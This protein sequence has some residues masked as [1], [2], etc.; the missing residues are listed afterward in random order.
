LATSSLWFIGTAALFAATPCGAQ[1]LT[2]LA[3]FDGNNGAYVPAGLVQAT[4]GNLYGTTE[5]GGGCCGAEGDGTVFK[6]SPGGTLTALHNFVGTDGANPQA[7]L[8]Q[9]TDGNLYGTTSGGGGAGLGTVFKITPEGTLTTLHTFLGTDGG[10]PQAGLIQAADGNLYGTT[11]AGGAENDGTVFKITL[12]GTLTTLYS[13]NLSGYA[14]AGLIQAT[15]GNFYGT[16]SGEGPGTGTVFRMTPAG[17]LT[18]LHSFDGPDG[19]NP[20]A[21][22]IQATDGNFYG[23]TAGGGDCCGAEGDG[24][25]FKITTGGTLT[26][27]HSFDEADGENPYAPLIQASDGNFYGTTCLGGAGS[28][29]TVFKITAEGTLTT[30]HGF[31]GTDGS[32]PTNAGLIQATDG[33]LYGTTRLGGAGYLAGGPPYGTVFR[34]QLTGT[35]PY[36]CSNTTPPVITSVESASDY[37]GYSY[38]ASGSWLEIKGSNMADPADPRLSAAVNP[39]QWTAADFSGLNAPTSLDGISASISG[40]PAYVWYLSPGQINVQAPEDSALGNVPITVTNCKATSSPIMFDRRTYAPG[41]LAPANYTANGTQYMVATFASD[42]SYVLNTSTG[43]ALGL[44]SRPAKPGDLIIAYGIGFGDVTPTIPPGVIVTQSNTVVNPI[45]LSFG[46][47]PAILSYS[48]LAGG[49]VGLYEFYIT[50]PPRLT[51]GD[52]EINVTYNGTT[53]PQTMYLTVHN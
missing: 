19:A 36:T 8:I 34:L 40:K 22:L 46:S 52:Y 25:V 9:A 1:I 41:F 16:T 48:G 24:T 39:G 7:G 30:L 11:S 43:A 50:V 42:G 44:I 33:N 51:N 35:A 3:T 45:M 14:N 29:G 10:N 28:R 26:T 18:I 13:F 20:Q 15:D 32:C 6:I 37:G 5:A 31:D 47:A 2:T 12:G 23:T 38:F 4:D 53:V 49:F 21:G 27:L 17:T